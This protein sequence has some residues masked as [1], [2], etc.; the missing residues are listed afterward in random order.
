MILML[1]L[2]VFA[3]VALAALWLVLQPLRGGMPADPDAPEHRRG[4]AGGP[5]G[6]VGQ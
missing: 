4:G 3:L 6:G 1:G 2:P 5:A